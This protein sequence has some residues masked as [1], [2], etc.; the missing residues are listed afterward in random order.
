MKIIKEGSNEILLINTF[1][2]RRFTCHTCGCVFEATNRE[3]RDKSS[4]IDGPSYVCFCPFCNNEC[5]NYFYID[6]VS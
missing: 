5:Y 4:Q 6:P 1:Q 3:Y 2:P